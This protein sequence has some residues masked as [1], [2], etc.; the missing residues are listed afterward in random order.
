MCERLSVGSIKASSSFSK[1]FQRKDAFCLVISAAL[2]CIAGFKTRVSGFE[3]IVL[4]SSR[5]H[6][7]LRQRTYL[8]DYQEF[9]KN[10]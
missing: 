1:K 9:F 10:F 3:R 7:A 4:T 2:Q 8:S 5:F 6:Q